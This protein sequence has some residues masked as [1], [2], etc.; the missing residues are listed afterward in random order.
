MATSATWEE[1]VRDSIHDTEPLWS[2][3]HEK[4]Y[5]ISQ[6]LDMMW[7]AHAHHIKRLQEM[8][9]DTDHLRKVME[10]SI[11][12]IVKEYDE[13][14]E[15][16]ACKDIK[17]ARR[18]LLRQT[19]VRSAQHV[20][21][22]ISHD[23]LDAAAAGDLFSLVQKVGHAI[24][25]TIELSENYRRQMVQETQSAHANAKGDA[26]RNI[27]QKVR[28]RYKSVFEN[29]MNQKTDEKEQTKD[30]TVWASYAYQLR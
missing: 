29:I 17:E 14:A 19:A 16:A 1:F 22:C 5:N 13:Q 10:A 23:V 6:L 24:F 15:I 27:E 30:D 12:D 18:R 21:S 4:H 8:G 7:K 11:L 28:M 2:K 26:K 9:V 20:F 3:L 25:R